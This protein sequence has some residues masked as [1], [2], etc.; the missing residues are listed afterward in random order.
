MRFSG[1]ADTNSDRNGSYF[2]AHAALGPF[3]GS[4]VFWIMMA[5]Y[6]QPSSILEWDGQNYQTAATSF[7]LA[8]VFGWFVGVIPAKLHAYLMTLLARTLRSQ[9]PWVLLTPVVSWLVST[10]PWMFGVWTSPSK[11]SGGCRPRGRAFPASLQ[12]WRAF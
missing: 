2:G 1:A 10:L 12:L 11:S 3:I 4:A 5:P 7:V 9:R 6:Q 8:L